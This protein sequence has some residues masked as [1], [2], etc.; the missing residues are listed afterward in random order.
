[1]LSQRILLAFTSHFCKCF[2]MA[3]MT[4]VTMRLKADGRCGVIQENPVTASTLMLRTLPRVFRSHH[5]QHTE[6]WSS[7]HRVTEH[8]T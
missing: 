5:P 2:I 1:M 4:W 3:L 8:V 6:P 7:L